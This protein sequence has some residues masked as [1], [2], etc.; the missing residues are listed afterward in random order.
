MKPEGERVCIVKTGYRYTNEKK[1][2]LLMYPTG[3]KMVVRNA[4]LYAPCLPMLIAKK[5][6]QSKKRHI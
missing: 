2:A 3:N 6:N 4:F 1:T 5:T